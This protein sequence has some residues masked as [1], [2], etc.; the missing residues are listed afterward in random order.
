MADGGFGRGGKDEGEDAI[1]REVQRTQADEVGERKGVGV[2]RYLA[3][4]VGVLEAVF[5]IGGIADDEV[6]RLLGEVLKGSVKTD[7][8]FGPWRVGKVSSCL[9]GGMG[10]DI[11]TPD[12]GL[13]TTLRQHQCDESAARTDV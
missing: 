12:C 11:D 1:G 5:K 10:V 3:G 8:S 7:E 4:G 13:G 9:G 2:T 6:E